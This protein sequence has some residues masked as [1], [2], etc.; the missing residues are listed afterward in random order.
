LTSTTFKSIVDCIRGIYQTGDVIPLHEPRFTGH[1]KKYLSECI[2]STFVSSVS[3]YVDLLEDRIREYTGAGYAIAA[4]NGT[5][6]LHVALLLAGVQPG[7][8]V[9]T[10]P[11]TFIATVNAIRYAGANPV[12]IDVDRKTPGL[13]PASLD[14]F[15]SKHTRRGKDGKAYN[16]T[17]GNRISACLPMHTFGHPVQIDEIIKLCSERHIPVIEDAAESLGSFYRTDHTGTRGLAGVL[18]FNGNKI[19]TT[20][21][22]GMIITNNREFAEKARHLTT[23]ARISHPWEYIHD[24]VGF[25][26]RLPGINAALGCAQMESLEAFLAAKREVAQTYDRFFSGTGIG[27]IREPEN[28]R[29]NYWLNS[30]LFDDQADRDAFLEYANGQGIQARPVWKLVNSLD[31]YRDCL[32]FNDENARFFEQRLVNLPSSVPAL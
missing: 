31:M 27:F 11:L 1:E 5:A 14:D 17:T 24:V 15:F 16:K 26:Y 32:S 22:G 13:S 21:G 10:Q 20:G 7:D 23:Q 4:S 12:F 9:I 30:I 3:K 29:S 18:S 2:D 6:A 8:E 19:I 25:N 28:C